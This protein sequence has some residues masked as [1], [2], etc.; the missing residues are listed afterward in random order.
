MNRMKRFI[1]LIFIGIVVAG[2]AACSDGN[3]KAVT[4]TPKTFAKAKK[5]ESSKP[6]VSEENKMPEYVI[7]GERDPFKLFTIGTTPEI[8]EGKEQYL[9]PLQK[10]TLSQIRLV[11]I[12]WGSKKSALIQDF[13]GIG[14]IVKEGMFVGENSGIVTRI[15][16][17]GITIKQHFKDYR[18]RVNTREAVLSLRKEEGEK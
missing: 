11:G 6:V 16:P 13:S 7:K 3:K 15:S 5:V 9:S 1:Y 8:A 14:Y 4:Y 2:L 12:I 17:N 18:G 10:L